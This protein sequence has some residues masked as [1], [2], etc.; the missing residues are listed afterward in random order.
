[1]NLA[2]PLIIVLVAK[3]KTFIIKGTALHLSL[4]A[5]HHSCLNQ[6]CPILDPYTS[7]KRGVF[8]HRNMHQ[9]IYYRRVKIFQPKISGCALSYNGEA[10]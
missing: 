2:M 5:V 4:I 7:R 10:E 1:M 6:N 3:D 9:C 8:I